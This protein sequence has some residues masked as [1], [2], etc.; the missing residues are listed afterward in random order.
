M[1]KNVLVIGGAGY[2]GSKLRLGLAKT[3]SVDC[4]DTCW[5][6]YDT[7]VDRRMDYAK[8]TT[9][10]LAK[11][12]VVVLLAGHS[13]VA[14]CV[15]PINSPWLNNVSNFTE[16]LKKL[17][18]DQTVIYASSASVY[19]NS[20]PGELHQETSTK[21]F[22][23]VNNYDITKY[24]LDLEAAKAIAQGREI[25][26][27]RFG[28]VNG[29]APYIR[30]DVMINAMYASAQTSGTV[31]VQNK[32][33]NRALLGI[34]DLC[35]AVGTIIEQPMS[36]IYNLASFNTTVEQI[37]TEVCDVIGA[38]L[39]NKGNTANAYDFG[40][41]CGLFEQKYG[42]TFTDTPAT[43]VQSLQ[44]GYASSKIGRRDNY[45]IYQWEQSN[46]RER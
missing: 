5:Y 25:I 28:T 43:I 31:T 14:S 34:D 22:I 8:L 41:D 29:W 3:Y 33:I 26:G 10:D 16:L 6:N 44:Q 2:I 17:R 4:V 18:H 1:I 7:T 36:G 13:S 38:K 24:S 12:D 20:V 9:A 23:P 32:L 35:R 45:M 37:A 30:T 42:F 11:Y 40:L 46:A 27:L 21:P 39:V 15:G 19:G